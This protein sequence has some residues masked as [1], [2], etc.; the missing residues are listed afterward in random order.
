[1]SYDSTK[2][3]PMKI[4][5]LLLLLV[6]SA[7]LN[8]QSP[9]PDLKRTDK[10]KPTLSDDASKNILIDYQMAVIAQDQKVTAD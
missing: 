2:G 3:E 10:P 8:A 1:M 9:T 5:R 7:L 4:A 6:T